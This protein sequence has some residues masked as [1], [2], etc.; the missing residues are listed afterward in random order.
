MSIAWFL[1]ALSID[2]PVIWHVADT[3]HTRR[4]TRSTLRSAFG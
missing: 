1:N 3:G 4:S 2:I